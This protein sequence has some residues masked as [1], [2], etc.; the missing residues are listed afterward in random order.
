MSPKTLSFALDS[1]VEVP[2]PI[3]PSVLMVSAVSVDVAK[4]DGDAVAT[5]RL[6]LIDRNVHGFDVRLVSASASCGPVDDAIW[7]D[8]FGV[9]V[10]IPT[11]CAP[12]EKMARVSVVDVAHFESGVPPPDPHALEFAETVP[13]AET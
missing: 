13:F 1:G 2:I 5:K 12:A 3:A 8:H 10:P 9:D 6:P 4:V 7:R 11:R